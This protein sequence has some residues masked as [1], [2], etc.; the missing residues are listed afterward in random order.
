MLKY[1]KDP[2]YQKSNVGK[3]VRKNKKF[4]RIF[5]RIQQQKKASR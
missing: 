4:N 2:I 1:R 3:E 5:D